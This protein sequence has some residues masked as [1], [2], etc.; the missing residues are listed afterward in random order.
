MERVEHSS[1]RMIMTTAP[2]LD[3]QMLV[4]FRHGGTLQQKVLH[5]VFENATHAG[6]LH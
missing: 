1:A 4:A 3:G 6:A 2:S 5:S